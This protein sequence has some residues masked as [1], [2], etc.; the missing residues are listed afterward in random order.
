MKL[1]AIL[2]IVLGALFASAQS[3]TPT[4]TPT[5]TP[6]PSQSSNGVTGGGVFLILFF[7]GGFMYVAVGSV[8]KFLA[9]I[10]SC[11]EMMPHHELWCET[12]PGLVH[13][14]CRFCLVSLCCRG[15]DQYQSLN[16]GGQSQPL[17]SSPLFTGGQK[18]EDAENIIA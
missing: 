17:A 6:S 14:G 15:H 3:P 16:S 5:A 8:M 2:T 13:E 9:G 12:C 1:L 7:V 11:P 18:Y 10:R 4:M